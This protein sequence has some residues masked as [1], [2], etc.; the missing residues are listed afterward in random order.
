VGDPETKAGLFGFAAV[1]LAACC[2]LPLLASFGILGALAGIGIG[3]WVL[4][5]AGMALG[6][7][8]AWHWRRATASETS[9]ASVAELRPVPNQGG[10]PR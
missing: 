5:G 8:G 7:V 2:G 4:I 3:N 9:P 10:P 6:G 1:G